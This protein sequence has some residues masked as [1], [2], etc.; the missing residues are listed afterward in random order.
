VSGWDP[1]PGET[2]IDDRSG[3]LLKHIRSRRALNAAEARNIGKAV[4][5][6]LAARPSRRAAPFH[7]DW[8]L[9][10]HREM[11]GEVWSWAGQVRRVE[12]NLGAPAFRI[13]MDL[14]QL[15]DDLIAWRLDP[16]M[17]HTE[18]AAR[19]HHRAVLIHPFLNGNGRWA[20]MLANI[21]M[22]QAG[23]PLTRWP[24]QTLGD[25][26]IIR[27]EY[28]AAIRAADAG[29]YL[30]LIDLHRRHEDA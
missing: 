7:L 2:P 30:H 20:R 3:L 15:V 19:L 12:L 9:K 24:E 18:Q 23:H 14:Q 13:E 21:L 27:A 25:S 11:F 29:E 22:R 6:Y 10:L 17:H 5:K 16:T 8:C 28:L 1:I 26:S 4:V